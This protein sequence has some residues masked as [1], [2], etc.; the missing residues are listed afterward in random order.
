MIPGGSGRD[1]IIDLLGTPIHLLLGRGAGYRLLLK[2]SFD[3]ANKGQFDF[4][5]HIPIAPASTAF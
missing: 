1:M 5:H 2:N 3:L 4:Y